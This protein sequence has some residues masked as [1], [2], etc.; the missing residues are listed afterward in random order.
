MTGDLIKRN[1]DSN[2]FHV[3]GKHYVNMKTKI[4]VKLLQLKKHQRNQQKPA[5]K[6]EATEKALN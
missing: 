1:T 6:P 5:K 4:E 2:K 3:Q